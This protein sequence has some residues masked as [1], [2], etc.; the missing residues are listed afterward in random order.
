MALSP[1]RGTRTDSPKGAKLPLGTWVFHTAVAPG[2][3]AAPPQLTS[4]CR[5]SAGRPGCGGDSRDLGPLCCSLLSRI[6][7]EDEGGGAG[8]VGGWPGAWVGFTEAQGTENGDALPR[9]H[10]AHV[11]RLAA[12]LPRLLAQI[13][14]LLKP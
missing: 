4:S 10:G 12:G 14:M 9:G 13:F 6:P 7:G 1:Q 8:G 3:L 2:L 11:A 5:P